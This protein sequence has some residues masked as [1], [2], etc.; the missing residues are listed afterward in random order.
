VG[1]VNRA[2]T[3]TGSNHQTLNCSKKSHEKV[4][5]KGIYAVNYLNLCETNRVDIRPIY[6]DFL[7]SD[8]VE[9]LSANLT[10]I[11]N[12]LPSKHIQVNQQGSQTL[13]IEWSNGCLVA[14]IDH[15][16]IAINST[17]PTRIA[18]F[19]FPHNCAT[20]LNNKDHLVQYRIVVSNGQITCDQKNYGTIIELSQCSQYTI[21][22]TPFTN[23]LM[24]E[25]SQQTNFT[26]DSNST[27]TYDNMLQHVKNLS[28]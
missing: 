20:A 25:F 4:L 27:Y 22:I 15:W 7:F 17:E 12:Q 3:L 1:F 18:N 6:S 24:N 23:T 14:Q 21:R 9:S 28:R 10:S 11:P 5:C 13:L 8:K 26:T 16:R 2:I 19:K